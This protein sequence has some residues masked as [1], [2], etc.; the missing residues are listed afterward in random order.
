DDAKM[1]TVQQLPN[2]LKPLARR[3]AR[4]VR[5]DRF[6]DDS[7]RIIEEIRRALD[8]TLTKGEIVT[9]GEILKQG[10]PFTERMSDVRMAAA[11]LPAA[12]L[13]LLLFRDTRDVNVL[14]Y[15]EAIV[16]ALQGG[17]DPGGYLASGEDL[18]IQLQVFSG[19][20]QLERTA[21]QTLDSFCHSLTVV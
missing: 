21:A 20:P 11:H 3:N 7:D 12:P 18:G 8:Q 5:N 9:E 2:E 15:E 14:P 19:A 17:R 4:E 10:K 1:P 6:S 16:R 13:Q